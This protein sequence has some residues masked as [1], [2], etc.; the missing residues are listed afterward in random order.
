MK[1]K[2]YIE[3]TAD[4]S[5]TFLLWYAPWNEKV[6]DSFQRITRKE[7]EHK[8]VQ[9]RWAR[10]N[11]S[12][13]AGYGSAYIWPYPIPDYYLSNDWIAKDDNYTWIDR[14]NVH[15]IYDLPNCYKY[16]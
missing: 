16:D 12:S 10:K 1:N 7:A 4:F 14:Y 15:I 11:D 9:E 8:A 6:P 13:F 2:Y 3:Y 5:N